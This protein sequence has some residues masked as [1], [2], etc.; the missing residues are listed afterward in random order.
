[1]PAGSRTSFSSLSL[2]IKVDH[3]LRSRSRRTYPPRSPSSWHASC[4]PRPTCP[5]GRYV[6]AVVDPSER[7]AAAAH[8]NA[9]R[10]A[11]RP[12]APLLAGLALR[13]ALGTPFLIAGALKSVY[14][15]GLYS[16]FG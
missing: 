13:G 11:T 4:S 7:T 12:L 14:D 5:R 10:Y 16:L 1:M 2:A 3:Q 6:V 15:L 9:A 8:T